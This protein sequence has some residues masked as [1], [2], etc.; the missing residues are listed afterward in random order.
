MS[1]FGRKSVIAIKGGMSAF[2]QASNST[3][4]DAS[5]CQHSLAEPHVF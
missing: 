5:V 2:V 4:G 3:G 1:V